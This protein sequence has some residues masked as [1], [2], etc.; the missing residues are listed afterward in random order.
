MAIDE[1]GSQGTGGQTQGREVPQDCYGLHDELDWHTGK[2]NRG[3]EGPKLG[4][5]AVRVAAAAV[6]GGEENGGE[7]EEEREAEE[8][9]EEEVFLIKMCLHFGETS[10]LDFHLPL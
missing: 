10:C 9:E 8:E 4:C 3:C 7:D 1:Q 5:H 6:V 2:K